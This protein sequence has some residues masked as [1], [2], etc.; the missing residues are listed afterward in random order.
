MLGCLRNETVLGGLWFG[1]GAWFK[2]RRSPRVPRCFLASRYSTESTGPYTDVIR[3][4][5][6]AHLPHSSISRPFYWLN[7]RHLFSLCCSLPLLT[8]YVSHL[9]A[10]LQLLCPSADKSVHSAQ[11][12]RKPLIVPEFGTNSD[13]DDFLYTIPHLLLQPK[14]LLLGRLETSPGIMP[15][16]C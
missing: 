2:R 15:L 14:I 16:L 8:T 11:L 9:L 12:P 5:R 7:S 1:I 4:T 13:Q 3:G 10:A 6:D